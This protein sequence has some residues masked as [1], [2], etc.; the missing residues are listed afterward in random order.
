VPTTPTARAASGGM[1]NFEPAWPVRMCSCVSASTPG[2]SWTNSFFHGPI[3]SGSNTWRGSAFGY[4]TDGSMTAKDFFVEQQNLDKPETRKNQWGMTI[5]GP[6]VRDRMHFFASFERQDR[7]EGRSRHYPSRPDR[8]FSVAQQTNS[9]NYLGR[10]DHQINA[11]QNYSVRYLWDHQPNYNQVL[12]NG[13][14]ADSD[15]ATEE[16]LREDMAAARALFDGLRKV[17]VP[18]VGYRFAGGAHPLRRARCHP[19]AVTSF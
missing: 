15:P 16:A 17:T 10:L 12:G 7:D 2:R 13:I 5:G 14:V 8:S 1:P 19:K 4:F 18:R 3:A 9:W 11:S 6:I